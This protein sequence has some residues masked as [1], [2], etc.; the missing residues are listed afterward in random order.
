MTTQAIK[1][2]TYEHWANEKVHSAMMQANLPPDRTL[3]L[4]S[5]ILAVSSIWL[6]R[7]KGETEVSKRFDR[8]TLEECAIRNNELLSDWQAYITSTPKVEEKIMTFTLLGQP[9]TMTILDCINH[10]TIHGSYHRGQIVSLL[11][12]HLAEM[13]LTDYVLYARNEN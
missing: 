8:Y 4:F 13:P 7:A 2:I 11:K 9:S 3:E 5:H 6:S 10:V 12:E 1:L